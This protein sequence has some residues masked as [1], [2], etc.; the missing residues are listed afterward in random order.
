MERPAK[1]YKYQP[2]TAQTLT[3]LTRRNW[4]FAAP[5][6]FNDPFDCQYQLVD[7]SP[8][9]INDILALADREGKNTTGARR[10]LAADPAELSK[11]IAS[12]SASARELLT[13]SFSNRGVCCFSARLDSLLMWGHYADGHRGFCLE[14]DTSSKHFRPLHPVSYGAECPSFSPA[15]VLI[16]KGREPIDIALCS[17]PADWEYEEEWRLLHDI[18]GTEYGYGP[19][20]LTAIYFG[21]R[22]DYT[23]TELLS[24]A[25]RG[26]RTG[27]FRTHLNRPA[28]GLE[29]ESVEYPPHPEVGGE[30]SGSS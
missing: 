26:S 3:N 5:A 27:L 1:L 19:E 21:A 13:K 29:F 14:F 15:Q 9:D 7:L 10:Q 20:A 28:Y 8:G 30:S 25:A 18:A 4:Y 2:F 17:K 23:H 11:L 24:L 16:P 6:A 22:M 12:S